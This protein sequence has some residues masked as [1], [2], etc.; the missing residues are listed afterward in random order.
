MAAEAVESTGVLQW[1]S[2][3]DA[4]AAIVQEMF[5]AGNWK[6]EMA[7]LGMGHADVPPSSALAKLLV[8]EDM[9]P[10]PP[11][12]EEVREVIGRAGATQ[13]KDWVSMLRLREALPEISG[14]NNEGVLKI[15]AH[16]P[17]AAS[18]GSDATLAPPASSRDKRKQVF[19]PSAHIPEGI[20][21]LSKRHRLTPA[22]NT[23]VKVEP[24]DRVGPSAG[25]RSQ[26]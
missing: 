7:D 10:R 23:T 1:S 11:S 25:T 16:R 17:S 6:K 12:E 2:Y 9:T 15:H 14:L 21:K 13:T 19:D 8:G 22:L 18:S 4:I 5:V 26:A 20:L 3:V 24:P